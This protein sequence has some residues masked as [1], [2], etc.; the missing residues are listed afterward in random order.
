MKENDILLGG[1]GEHPVY[2]NAGMANRHGL[3]TGATGTGKTVTMQ[4]MMESFSKMG[5]PV[6]S[7][8]VKGDLSGI[9]AAGVSNKK[10]DERIEFIGMEM[11]SF[12]GCPTA[13][14]DVYG[15][16]GLPVRTT[17]TE[18]GATLLANLLELNET[19][20]GV[21]Q[22]AFKVAENQ[23]LP[24]VSLEDLRAMLNWIGDH[25]N[26][27]ERRYGRI[28]T[29]TTTAILRRLLVLEQAGGDVFF[30]EPSFQIQHLIQHDYSGRGV[31]N[32]L[33]A[34]TLFHSPRIYATFLLWM[35]S[36]LMQKLP[37]RG[38]ADKP[39]LVFFFDEA[40]LLFNKA[41][42]ALVE[43][44]TQIVRLIRSRGVGVFFVSQY[45]DDVPNEVLGQLGNRVQ[46]AL[47][48]FTPQD[49]KALKAAAQT[50]RDN[51]NF[52]TET[53]I[54]EL[55][56]GEALISTLD[57][58][59]VPT[60]VERTL[61]A[62]PGSQIGP[63]DDTRRQEILDKSPLKAVYETVTQRETAKALIDKQRALEQQNAQREQEEAEKQKALELERKA[64]EKRD[65]ALAKQQRTTATKRAPASRE[66]PSEALMKSAARTL[67]SSFTRQI[68]Q[69]IIRAFFKK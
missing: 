36:T 49:R 29:A 33:D 45:P 51:P 18:M 26:E 62:P 25:A 54:S 4:M 38:D 21:L 39:L 66:S 35:L 19:Q 40:H 20:E 12:E 58:K 9:A 27:L 32:V 2:L 56:V 15:E 59:G 3:I 30:A 8:D 60:M 31:V 69:S 41:P 57:R 68:I 14:W 28:A 24:L 17:V 43:T 44:I 61:V 65:Q 50:F 63:L 47:R 10:I 13:F 64:Q 22:I 1:T 55:G 46:H 34:T 48:A 5:V 52:N 11:P 23:S 42:K 67:G 53:V 6:F 7:A 16:K 37:E